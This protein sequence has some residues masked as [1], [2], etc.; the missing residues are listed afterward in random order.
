MNLLRIDEVEA[1]TGL[2]RAT[3]GRLERA[4]RFPRRRMAAARSV[5]W[6]DKEVDRWIEELPESGRKGDDA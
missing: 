1:K 5:R 4:G 3:I 6:V 2:H